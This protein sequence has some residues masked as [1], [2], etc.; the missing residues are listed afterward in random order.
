MTPSSSLLY[1]HV[2]PLAVAAVCRQ[3]AQVVNVLAAPATYNP[4]VR[5]PALPP[6]TSW[7]CLLMV[8]SPSVRALIWCL[9]PDTPWTGRDLLST[10][11]W[12][13][14]KWPLL[15]SILVW[16]FFRLGLCAQLREKIIVTRAGA[17]PHRTSRFV[18][19]TGL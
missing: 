12:A 17:Q 4:L 19:L 14:I 3:Q 5:S 1:C 16:T 18:R 10:G 2:R 11:E 15:W 9:F 8:G 7:N 6:L 13:W